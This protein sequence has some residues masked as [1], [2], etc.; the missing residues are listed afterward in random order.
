VQLIFWDL[1]GQAGLRSIWDKYY[2]ESNALIYLIDA[3]AGARPSPH[4]DLRISSLLAAHVAD[5][6]LV[7]S[8]FSFG[9][10]SCNSWRYGFRQRDMVKCCEV[11]DRPARVSRPC[12]KLTARYTH[13]VAINAHTRY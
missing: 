5:R 12:F 7:T 9:T 10:T 11:V 3:S 6:L 1:G 2:A 13:A 4:A 8:C